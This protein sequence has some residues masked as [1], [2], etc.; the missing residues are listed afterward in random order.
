MVFSQLAIQDNTGKILFSSESAPELKKTFR[1]YSDGSLWSLDGEVLA[2]AAGDDRCKE[3]YLLV[4]HGKHF[5]L[6]MVPDLTKRADDPW[7]LP[8]R[9]LSGRRLVL[10]LSG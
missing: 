7:I 2:I 5:S 10:D 6:L 3:A 1:F 8:V 4:H 9:W